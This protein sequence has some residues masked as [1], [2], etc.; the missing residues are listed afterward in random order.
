M[1]NLIFAALLPLTV[2][3]ALIDDFE[4]TQTSQYTIGTMLGGERDVSL[5]QLY[6]TFNLGSSYHIGQGNILL[7]NGFGSVS[8]LTIQWDGLDSSMD[9]NPYGLGGI[10]LNSTQFEV[11]SDLDAWFTMNVWS[12]GEVNTQTEF[13]SQAGILDFGTFSNVGAVELTIRGVESYDMRLT[14]TV[15]VSAPAQN[16]GT[17][18]LLVAVII[19]SVFIGRFLARKPE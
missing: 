7:S 17:Y 11:A 15:E 4:D 10:N 18:I 8:E 3:A 2:N 6:D 13:V 9:I 19:V 5:N 12:G 14:P 16:L 1:K